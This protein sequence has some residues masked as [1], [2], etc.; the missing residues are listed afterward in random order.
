MFLCLLFNLLNFLL[1]FRPEGLRSLFLFRFPYRL[2]FSCTVPFFFPAPKGTRNR[3]AGFTFPLSRK[4]WCFFFAHSPSFL[5]PCYHR[6]ATSPV[7]LFL[8]FLF[9]ELHGW[10]IEFGFVPS[11]L[12][13]ACLTSLPPYL[14]FPRPF[15]LLS[16]ST[17]I[18]VPEFSP[19]L[20]TVPFL[21]SPADGPTRCQRSVFFV[22]HESDDVVIFAFF[23]LLPPGFSR[24]SF[25]NSL[26]WPWRFWQA[27]FTPPF[28]CMFVYCIL[29]PL[30][31]GS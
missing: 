8:P 2:F 23:F 29:V 25:L 15:K 13:S 3:H 16:F 30:W 14:L 9:F 27:L 22:S 20:L 4:S 5:L 1:S 21:F 17:L 28:S 11:P 19:W 18:P 31:G 24:R 26:F 7:F 10:E 6:A 12:A